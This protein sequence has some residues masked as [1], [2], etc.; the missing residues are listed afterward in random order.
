MQ[1]TLCSRCKKNVAVVFISRTNEKNETV[2][3][4]LCLKCA[5][6]LGLPQVED[7]MKR[8]GIS[9]DD[10]EGL[11]NEMMQAFGG[12]EEMSDLPEGDGE[13]DEE[14][15]KTA[16]FPFLNRLFGSGSPAEKPEE[17]GAAGGKSRD[18]RERKADKKKKYLD[19]YCINLSQR[20]R[21]GKLDAVIGRAEEIERVVQIL[22]RRQKNNPCLIGEPGVGKTAIAEGLAQRIVTGEVPF[23]LRDKEVYLLDLTALVAGTQ[24]R[25]QFESRMKGLIEEIR[26][27]G[28]VILVIDEVHNIVGAGDAEGSMNAANILK[29]ALSRGEI[30]VIGATTFNEYRKH[31]EKDTALERRFQ[32]V[33]VNEPSMEDTL[34]ILKGIAHYYES[35]H[36]VKIPEGILRQ[37]VK[38]SE[39]Y[40]TDR[41]LP[42]KA[43]DLIDEACSDMN[44]HDK[45]INRRMEL[46]RD[47]ENVTFERETLMSAEPEEGKELTEEQLDARYARIAELRSQEMRIQGELEELE[48]LGTPELTMDNIAR[49]IELWTKI[50]A[51][52]IREEEYKR[53]SELDQR[54]KQHIVG[55]DEAVEAVTA[56][57]RRNR[58][59]ISPKHK[60]V[61]FIFVG[62]TGVGKTEL[63]KQLAAD[64]FD[65]PESLIR[66]DMSEFMEKHSVSRIVGSPPGYVGYDEAGQLTE[67]I[68]RKPYS[69]IL[70]DEIEKA[71]PD[72]LNV[73]LQILD[74]GELTDAHGRKVNFENTVIV[75]TSNAGSD[76]AGGAVGFG[77]TADEQGKERVMKAL[78]EFLRPEFINRVDEIIYFN[79][80][81]EENFTHIARIMLGELCDSLADKGFTFSWDESLEA[82]LVKKSYS[83]TY[84]ARNLRRTIQKELED[85]I[86]VAIIDS[87]DHPITQIKAVCEDDAVKLYTL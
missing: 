8:M 50:P 6:Q 7:M 67:K 66:L 10:L 9:P 40:I 19:N 17:G 82:Y 30:Q 20:A 12:A 65:S 23:K 14:S 43:I 49:V 77:R 63:V 25:G 57:I 48:K 2:N 21:D 70:F 83:V 72:V 80:L 60:P 75:M 11:N 4:G 74:D 58:V 32:P 1:P 15:G 68:R 18:T 62:S 31:I 16:T 44:L 71:H 38:L 41:F 24:F 47:L 53:L 3:E 39:R 86:S 78:Q 56:A 73:L 36:G 42:D 51:S 76:R 33:I 28:N 22:N 13:D 34:K 85:P 79:R 5:A 61:S 81:T 45:N 37:A 55:Q 26:K 27:L 46:K 29:P 54:L 59:G 87:Y 52:K 35:F 69:V 84:G 64:L